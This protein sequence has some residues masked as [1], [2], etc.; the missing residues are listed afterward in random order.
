MVGG[1]KDEAAGRDFVHAL[2]GEILTRVAGELLAELIR[3]GDVVGLLTEYNDDDW[4]EGVV[5][6][7]VQQRKV[8]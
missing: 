8:L 7:G 5:A 6:G 2:G 3:K 1:D 4:C